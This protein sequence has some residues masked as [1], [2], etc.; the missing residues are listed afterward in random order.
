MRL[1]DLPAPSSTA[2]A[3]LQSRSPVC[4]GSDRAPRAY[5]NRGRACEDNRAAVSPICCARDRQRL[6]R[7]AGLEPALPFEKQIL[8]PL[9]SLILFLSGGAKS[10]SKRLR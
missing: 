10:F 3:C 4:R 9:L 2:V 7:T 1:E 8:S 5:P 6:V